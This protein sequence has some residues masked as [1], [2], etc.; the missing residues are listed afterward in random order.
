VLSLGIVTVLGV[1]TGSALMAL[2]TQR[3]R[4]EGFGSTE[5]VANHLVGA[6]LMGVGGVTAMGCTVGQGLSGVST[7][8]VMSFLA[9]AAIVLGAVMA[10]KYQTWR[11]EKTA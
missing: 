1:I 8:S 6:V 3:F 2:A 9:V 4:W 10:F 5:D 7:L 11:L